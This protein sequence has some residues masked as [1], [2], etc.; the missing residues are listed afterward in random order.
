MTWYSLMST[1][2]CSAICCALPA[3]RTLKPMTTADDALARPTSDSVMPPTPVEITFTPTVSVDSCVSALATASIE[4]CTSAL[5]TTL[6]SLTSPDLILSRMFSSDTRLEPASSFLRRASCRCSTSA[7]A[8]FSSVTTL[9]DFARVGDAVQAQHLDRRRRTGLG[10]RLSLVAEHG[11]DLPR[12]FARDD[13]VADA[14]RPLL[15]Q[16]GRDGATRAIESRLDDVPLGE[17]VRVR[18]QLEHLGLQRQHLEQLVDALLGLRRHVDVDRRA[19][20]LLG[21]Q[22]VLRQLGAHDVGV[23]ARLVDLVHRDDD[24][25]LRRLGVVD[26]LDRLRHRPVVGGD[27]QDDDVRHLRAAGA[28]RRERL[29]ARR[30]QEH[31]VATLAGHLVG[32]DVLRDAARLARRR[33]SP[34]GSRRAATSCRGRRGP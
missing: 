18:A 10:Q 27:D 31:D 2:S 29:V 9:N 26:G 11:A 24:G 19:A 14:Q 4:P 32:A 34:C 33:R 17:L 12:V 21:D 23:G 15:D 5:S 13:Q 16:D 20:P 25:D 28:H 8:A 1:P 6:T 3:G 7:L 30:I 22:V